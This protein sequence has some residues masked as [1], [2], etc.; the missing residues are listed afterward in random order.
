[1]AGTNF[2]LKDGDA[3]RLSVCVQTQVAVFQ[4]RLNAEKN[5]QIKE[6]IRKDIAAYSDLII[7]LG[8]A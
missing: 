8:A 3:D 6:I 7:R 4:R 5:D 2:V 1:M